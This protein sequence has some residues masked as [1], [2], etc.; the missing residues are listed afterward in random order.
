[1]WNQ[2]GKL[3]EIDNRRMVA[4][5]QGVREMKWGDTGPRGQNFS[6]NMSVLET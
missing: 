2:K 3:T 5:G 4:K 1:M 6:Y